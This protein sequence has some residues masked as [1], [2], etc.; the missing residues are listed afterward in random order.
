MLYAANPLYVAN[1]GTLGES[2]CTNMHTTC[3]VSNN[4]QMGHV[5]IV[6]KTGGPPTFAN[7]ALIYVADLFANRPRSRTL[8]HELSK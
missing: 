1:H 5:L 3:A 2:P 4:S 7:Y 6:C 8:V